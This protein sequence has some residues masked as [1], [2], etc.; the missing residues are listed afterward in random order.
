MANQGP[1]EL[2]K[3]TFIYTMVGTIIYIGVVF[4]FVLHR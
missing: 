3:R 4:A 1:H 2:A